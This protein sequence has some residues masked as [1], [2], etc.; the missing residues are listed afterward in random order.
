MTPLQKSSPQQSQ[1]FL[2]GSLLHGAPSC[3]QQRRPGNDGHF[4]VGNSRQAVFLP[5]HCP[6]LLHD[7]PRLRQ[8]PASTSAP[9]IPSRVASTTEIP[10][11]TV[12]TASRRGM[13]AISFL[14][15]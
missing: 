2:S 6:L 13:L 1:W 5:Q 4:P 9:P 11:A 15:T 3:P 14:A 8:F 12:F 7:R 10:P